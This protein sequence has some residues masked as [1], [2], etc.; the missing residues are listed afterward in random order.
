MSNLV[1]FGDSNAQYWASSLAVASGRS[2]VNRA[3]SGHQAADLGHEAYGY[4][5]SNSLPASAYAPEADALGVVAIG[6]NDQRCNGP[7]PVK[8]AQFERFL[9]ADILAHALPTKINARTPGG[10]G[11]IGPWGNTAVNAIGKYSDAEGAKVSGVVEGTAVYVQFLLQ[12]SAGA[13]TTHEVTID[14]ALHSTVTI[15][16]VGMTTVNGRAWAPGC[17]RFGGLSD[18][19]HTVEIERITPSTPFQRSYVD[20]IAGSDQTTKPKAIVCTI[21][22]QGAAAY[23][24]LPGALGSDAV[25]A[26]YNAVIAALVGALRLDGLDV[27]LCDLHAIIDPATDLSDFTHYNAAGANKVK[28]ALLAVASGPPP[29]FTY[30][31]VNT[32]LRSDGRVFVGPNLDN[33]TEIAQSL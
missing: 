26:D 14:G 28:N 23:T 21:P 29:E 8:R 2:L 1:V 7:N 32:Y 19:P 16:G 20:W 9:L 10:L 17:V 30:A 22:K 4:T 12:D 31:S 5:G 33:L 13:V 6:T 24:G 15:S 18:G 25:I 11:F 3:A 27:M